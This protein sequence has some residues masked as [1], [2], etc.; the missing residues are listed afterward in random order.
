LVRSWP[1]GIFWLI[2]QNPTTSAF[3]ICSDMKS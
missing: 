3:V 2:K 1:N